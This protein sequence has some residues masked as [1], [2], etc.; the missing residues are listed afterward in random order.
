[1]VA[2]QSR[3]T[4]PELER[5]QAAKMAK[6]TGLDSTLSAGSI[7]CYMAKL[8]ALMT[9]AVNESGSTRIRRPA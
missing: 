4:I 9:F 2:Q 8:R 6:K 1:M 3:Q 5:R 7:N